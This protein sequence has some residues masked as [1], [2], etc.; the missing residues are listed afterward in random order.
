MPEWELTSYQIARSITGNE[1]QGLCRNCGSVAENVEPDACN[2]KCEACGKSEVF[3]LEELLL[4]GEI[5][6]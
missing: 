6:L 4:M 2:Y 3:G 5:E 1:D